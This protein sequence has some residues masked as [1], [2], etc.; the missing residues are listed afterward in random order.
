MPMEA[1]LAPG[2]LCN[3][4]GWCAIEPFFG[5]ARGKASDPL[6]QVSAVMDDFKSSVFANLL[7]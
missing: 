1:G 6:T 4:A 3:W 5:I 7:R 2:M